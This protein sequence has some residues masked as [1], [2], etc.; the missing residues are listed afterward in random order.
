MML[1]CIFGTK[2]G[3]GVLMPSPQ[4][5]N[6]VYG[7]HEQPQRA[8]GEL[9]RKCQILWSL[10]KYSE[11]TTGELADDCGFRMK[12]RSKYDNVKRELKDLTTETPYL[13]V[14]KKN[15]PNTRSA[16]YYRICRDNEIILQLYADSRFTAL[17]EYFWQSDWLR[18]FLID[19]QT[20]FT[21]NDLKEDMR[22][23]LVASPTF[24]GLYLQQ[25]VLEPTT[26]IWSA[27]IEYP[28]PSDAWFSEK[29][30]AGER[31]RPN[32][33]MLYNLFTFCMFADYLPQYLNGTMDVEHY[34]LLSQMGEKSSQYRRTA[35][36]YQTSFRIME[37]L[38]AVR[39]LGTEMGSIP[40]WLVEKLDQYAD[41]RVGDEAIPETVDRVN[42]ELDMIYNEIAEGLGLDIIRKPDNRVI[43]D[44]MKELGIPFDDVK[45]IVEE[46]LESE[47]T[48]LEQ[49]EGVSN[50]IQ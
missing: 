42:A 35:R 23:M 29:Y 4:A 26:M 36:A 48:R 9:D 30:V 47:L 49:E 7:D 12:K 1:S 22:Q 46:Y 40:R 41:I 28:I 37:A 31:G 32:P 39:E 14:E 33:N 15:P 13:E 16:T 11:R 38:L 5:D 3:L 34:A 20:D 17:R 43:A 25:K 6:S 24:F 18:K 8:P 19:N 21:T 44:F 50:E 10:L 45:D 2:F 27:C